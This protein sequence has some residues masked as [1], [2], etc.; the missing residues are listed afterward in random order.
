[1]T[2]VGSDHSAIALF[3]RLGVRLT[4]PEYL[5]LA[6][7]HSSKNKTANNERLEFLGDR[8]LGLVLAD[9]LY[10]QYPDE[11][12]GDQALRHAA[13]VRA[14]TLATIARA[15]HL[16]KFIHVSEHD[17]GSGTANLDNVLADCLEAVI[18]AVYLDQGFDACRPLVQKLWHDALTTM[19]EPPQDPKT[20]LQELAQG[21]GLNLPQYDLVGRDGP[22][23]APSFTI[24]VSIDTL[25]A[26][27][28]IG[29]S[30]AR[31][32]KA[33]AALLLEQLKIIEKK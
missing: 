7:T 15:I 3:E 6:L 25:G 32:E 11:N 12:E 31:A 1:M 16:N 20:A 29:S 30:R 27:S 21:R 17:R 24:R 26:A 2:A 8:V 19:A 9:A 33:A 10:H 23:H 22:D 4:N 28:A 14:E 13:L 18:G 5:E